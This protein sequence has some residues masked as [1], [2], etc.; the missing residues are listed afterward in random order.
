MGSEH[1]SHPH[2][3]HQTSESADGPTDITAPRILGTGTQVAASACLLLT[4]LISK[5]RRED[6][7][8]S[9]IPWKHHLPVNLGFHSLCRRRL[10]M[11][12][13]PGAPSGVP[14]GP[15]CLPPQSPP[16]QCSV[17]P[18]SGRGRPA[19]LPWPRYTEGDSGVVYTGPELGPASPWPEPL[20]A[21]RTGIPQIFPQIKRTNKLYCK[22]KQSLFFF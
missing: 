7:R 5:R 10:G 6:S 14:N 8:I 9:S 2:M 18:R 3:S 19:P 21:L 20:T 11:G 16:D 22:N 12:A 13:V 17:Q 4:F 1:P 15:P